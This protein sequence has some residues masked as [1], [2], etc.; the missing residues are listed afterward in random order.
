MGNDMRTIQDAAPSTLSWQQTQAFQRE[1]ELRAGDELLATLRKLRKLGRA[2]EAETG[3]SRFTF[4]PSGFLR[5]RITI[6]EDGAAGE[7]AVF[8]NGFCSGGRLLLPD[9]RSYRFK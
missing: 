2:M 6:R 7:P 3:A 5:P 8:Q 9:G 1:Y 4:E